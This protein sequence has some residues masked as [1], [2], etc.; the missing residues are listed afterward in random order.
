MEKEDLHSASDLTKQCTSDSSKT[1]AS[2]QSLRK[3]SVDQSCL[4]SFSNAVSKQNDRFLDSHAKDEASPLKRLQFC[5]S[6]AKIPESQEDLE[7]SPMADN[8]YMLRDSQTTKHNK[9]AMSGF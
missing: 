7:E 5:E 1:S 8:P 4:M 3:P 6:P 9:F 2:D